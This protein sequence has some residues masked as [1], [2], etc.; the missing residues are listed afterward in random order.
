MIMGESGDWSEV[1]RAG[2]A[3]DV[4]VP[5]RRGAGAAGGWGGWTVR[6][7]Q[8]SLASEERDCDG[9]SWRS[10]GGERRAS[11]EGASEFTGDVWG[12]R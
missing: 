6:C 3:D 4:R 12:D 9:D 7:A 11:A 8:W 10:C 5:K 1:A 2:G